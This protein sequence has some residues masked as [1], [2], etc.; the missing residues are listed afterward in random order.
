M[1]DENTP[2]VN[3]S[4]DSSPAT[5]PVAGEE[6]DAHGDASADSSP[7][8]ARDAPS[9]IAMPASSVRAPSSMMVIQRDRVAV[10]VIFNGR[11]ST[12]TAPLRP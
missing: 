7:K 12:A 6:H 2:M 1:A 11:T 4:S 9:A 3:P 8:E 10:V 5:E